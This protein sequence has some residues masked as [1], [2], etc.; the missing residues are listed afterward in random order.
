MPNI[1]AK[2]VKKSG[3]RIKFI[4]DNGMTEA[5]GQRMIRRCLITGLEDGGS[6][7]EL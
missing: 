2:V 4:G 6:S 7:H 5:E 3:R 1:T